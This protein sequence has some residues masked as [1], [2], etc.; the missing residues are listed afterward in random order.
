VRL[1]LVDKDPKSNPTGSP[2]VDKIDPG[3]WV[4]QGWVVRDPKALAQT[5]VPKGETCVKTPERML[6]IFERDGRGIDHG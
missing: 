6:Q 5:D 3:S 4:V 1:T 2:N